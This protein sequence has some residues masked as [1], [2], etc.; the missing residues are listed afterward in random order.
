MGEGYV[1]L[2]EWPKADAALI[3]EEAER[4][5]KLLEGTLKDVEEI[6]KVTK[7][8]PKKI[9]LYTTPAWKRA[10]AGDGDGADAARQAGHGRSHEGG[11]GLASDCALQEGCAQVCPE[12]GQG[13]RIR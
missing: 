11:H 2:A 10:D 13:R 4:A 7:A 8:Q 3:D 12:A 6:I 1:S 5:E 9:T